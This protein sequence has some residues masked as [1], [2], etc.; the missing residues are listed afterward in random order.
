MLRVSPTPVFLFS[1]L[2]LPIVS[3]TGGC[4]TPDMGPAVAIPT[5][6]L[7]RT[8]V[9]LGGPLEMTYRF[10]V[11]PEFGSLMESYQ[12]FVEFLDADEKVMF[13]DDHIPAVA[14]TDWQPGQMVAYNRRMFIPLYPYVGEALI[15]LRLASPSTGDP[16]ALVGEHLG[17]GRYLAASV[18]LAPPPTSIPMFQA[19]WHRRERDSYEEWRWSTGEATIAFQN[20]RQ[21]STLYLELEGRPALFDS[22][23]RV[24]LVVRGRT[25]DSFLVEDPGILLHTTPVSAADF[26]DGDLAELVFHVDS[27]FVPA[28]LPGSNS[29]D[30]RRLGVRVFHAFVE[31]H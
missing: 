6:V 11:L 27:T 24:D 15:A 17:Q 16:V 2:L 13:T 9:P 26:G 23:Q 20:P 3:A 30:D 12:V 14:T 8:R 18:G 28:E 5:L 22:P 4:A 21:D 1:L 25:V 31:S 29:A 19:G 10:T 7:N